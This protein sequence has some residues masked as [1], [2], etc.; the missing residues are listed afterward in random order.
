MIYKCISVRNRTLPARSRTIVFKNQKQ[1]QTVLRL[2]LCLHNNYWER[3][4]SF[5]KK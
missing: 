3:N 1:P 4:K 2:F 5:Q